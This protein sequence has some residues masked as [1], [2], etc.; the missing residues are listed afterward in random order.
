MQKCKKCIALRLVMVNLELVMSK[1]KKLNSGA[2]ST[3]PQ[4]K[5]NFPQNEFACHL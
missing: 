1:K 3:I 2:V 5:H 4:P